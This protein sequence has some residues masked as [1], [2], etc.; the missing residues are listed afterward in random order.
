[1]SLLRKIVL[2]G[3]LKDQYPEFEVD[4]D[5]VAD[6]LEGW[7]RQCGIEGERPVIEV[8][9]YRT[10][11][12][13]YAHT[14]DNEIHLIPAM[15]GGSGT[16]KI[17]IGALMIVAAVVLLPYIGPSLSAALGGAGLSMI[18]GGVM[19]LFMKSPTTDGSNDP[20]P[21]KYLGAGTNTTKIGTLIPKG[22]GRFL[23]G[24]QYMSVQVNALDMVFGSFPTTP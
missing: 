4:G 5:S 2:H 21:S 8:V 13:L 19:Q 23:I 1:L 9:G 17:I 15:S 18:I 7:S 20:E 22:Y 14:N 3:T 6:A 12:Q 24:G 10:K 16:M 11:E